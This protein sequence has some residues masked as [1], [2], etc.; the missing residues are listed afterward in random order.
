M[1]PEEMVV[2]GVRMW[3]ENHPFTFWLM[4]GVIF[5]NLDIFSLLLCFGVVMGIHYG[6]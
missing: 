4:L 2:A 5:S 1:T 6:W 3:V